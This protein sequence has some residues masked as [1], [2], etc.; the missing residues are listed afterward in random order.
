ME[1]LLTSRTHIKSKK[2]W[3]GYVLHGLKDTGESVQ[4]LVGLDEAKTFKVESLPMLEES[5]IADFVNE[6]K[7]INITYNERGR[8]EGIEEA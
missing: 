4:V 6:N 2:G 1:M 5:V 7:R 8:V 3:E